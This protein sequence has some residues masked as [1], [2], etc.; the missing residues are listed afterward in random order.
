M[1][2]ARKHVGFIGLLS[3]IVALV[4]IIVF[5]L[6][7][8]DFHFLNDYLSKLG[9]AGE[10]HALAANL[11]GFVG[12]GLLL[13]VFG[14]LYGFLLKDRLLALLLSLFGVGLAF[15]SIP[16][17]YLHP[18]S[19]YSK[20]HIVVICLGLA[21]W[22]FGLSRLGIN[23]LLARKIRNRANRTSILL[24]LALSGYALGWWSMPITHRLVF[25]I[26][27]G[28]TGVTSFELLGKQNPNNQLLETS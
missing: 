2:V 25:G 17:D 20:A 28:W 15:T 14:W 26:V 5:G 22:L 3:V 19:V 10:P 21:S 11:I 6:L 12:T 23:L 13:I 27:F 1:E 8:H 7:N 24:V 16:T 4:G 9:A 18:D